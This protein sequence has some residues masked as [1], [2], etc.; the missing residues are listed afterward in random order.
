MLSH[1]SS[2]MVRLHLSPPNKLGDEALPLCWL[3]CVGWLFVNHVIHFV[4]TLT[5]ICVLVIFSPGKYALFLICHYLV[6]GQDM[7]KRA[8]WMCVRQVYRVGH[9]CMRLC[10]HVSWWLMCPGQYVSCCKIG[11]GQYLWGF[12]FNTTTS[13]A[14]EASPVNRCVLDTW[15]LFLHAADTITWLIHQSC[16]SFCNY[17]I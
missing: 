8:V 5:N 17:P 7:D 13:C 2:N 3:S 15:P 10:Q 12:F 14:E 16:N 9:Y 6:L 11:T 1:P 4:N